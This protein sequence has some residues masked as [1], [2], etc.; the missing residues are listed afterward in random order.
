MAR[1]LKSPADKFLFDVDF[2]DSPEMI[3]ISETHGAIGELVTIKLLC[4]I[5]R[6]GYYIEWT[7]SEQVKL[8]KQMPTVSKQKLCDIVEA[9][10]ECGFFDSGMLR[11]YRVL[12]SATIQQTHLETQ[13]KYRRSAES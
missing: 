4:D 5:H 1:P 13:R 9:L 6:N 11:E 8:L 12:T 10:V 2:F 3:Y 7:K